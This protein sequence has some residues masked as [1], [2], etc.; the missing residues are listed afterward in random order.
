M[1]D[2][3]LLDQRSTQSSSQRIR[4][5]KASTRNQ[6]ASEPQL[7]HSRVSMLGS[8]VRSKPHQDCISGLGI[9]VCGHTTSRCQLSKARRLEGGQAISTGCGPDLELGR[10]VAVNFEPNADFRKG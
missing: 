6:W 1:V 8:C 2:C 5:G 4:L 3:R 7:V 10:Q 9:T